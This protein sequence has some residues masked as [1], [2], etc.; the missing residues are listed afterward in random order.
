MVDFYS[1]HKKEEEGRRELVHYATGKW[2]LFKYVIALVL[3]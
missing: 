2:T 1:W 3:Y